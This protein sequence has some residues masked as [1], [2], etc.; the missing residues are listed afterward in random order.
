MMVAGPV[1]PYDRSPGF[2]LSPTY[3]L[4]PL[5]FP[6]GIFLWKLRDFTTH[7]S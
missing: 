1:Y 6:K 4:Q 5:T 7:D 2:Y 3:P